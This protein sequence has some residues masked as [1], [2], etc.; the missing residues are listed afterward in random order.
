MSKT[1]DA[2][3]VGLHQWVQA[4][5]PCDETDVVPLAGDASFRRYYR[6]RRG[7]ESRILVDSPPTHEKTDAFVGIAQAFAG[8]GVQVPQIMASDLKQGY[9]L[10][11]DFGDGLFSAHLNSSSVDGLYLSAIETLLKIQQTPRDAYVFPAFDEALL[12]AECQ[13]FTEWYLGQYL[14]LPLSPREESMLQST[15]ARLIELALAQPTTVVHRDYHSRNLLLLEDGQVGVL[16]FQDAVIGPITYD[17]ASLL[18]DCYVAWPHSNV[19]NWAQRYFEK[20]RQMGV[21]Q[22]ITMAQFLQWF[23]LM[24]VQRHLK[25]IGI[26]SR[27]NSRDKKSDYLAHIPRILDYILA[28]CARHPQLNGLAKLLQGRVLK[29]ESHDTRSGTRNAA[30]A[31]NG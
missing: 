10:L 11:S 28:T 6:V 2:R 29:H 7:A 27:L 22:D 25:C 5:F 20:G 26:F 15:Y 30:A 23:D 1:T 16:D 9:M 31:I 3:L 12:L 21:I 17:L 24:A 18:K 13:L 4:H 19:V 8:Q 14:K